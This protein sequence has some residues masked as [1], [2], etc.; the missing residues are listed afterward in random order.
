MKSAGIIS[1]ELGS[2]LDAITRPVARP[3]RRRC[4]GSPVMKST[5]GYFFREP[6]SL[7]PEARTADG[8]KQRRG[9][10]LDLVRFLVSP[11]PGEAET[12]WKKKGKGT[13]T[14]CLDVL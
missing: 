9:S 13:P 8:E 10:C 11:L 12:L 14:K 4:R 1:G 6:S 3:E 5:A 2:G 7:V